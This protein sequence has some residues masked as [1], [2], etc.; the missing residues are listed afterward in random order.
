MFFEIRFFLREVKLREFAVEKNMI[1]P[2]VRGTQFVRGSTT[3]MVDPII[4][5]K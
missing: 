1:K 3:S 4:S 5:G 2:T